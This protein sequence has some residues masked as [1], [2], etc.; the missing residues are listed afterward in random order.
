MP[1]QLLV[2]IFI[3]VLWMFLQNDWSISAF[4]LGYILGLLLIFLMRRFFNAP[5]Y[6]KRV[7]A[8]VSLLILFVRE[9][10]SSSI[11]ITK[12]IMSPKLTIKP[13]IFTME[14]SL[15]T[16]F[17][18]TL[19][20]LLL[21]LTPGS[22]VVELSEDGKTFYMHAMDIPDSS[23]MVL[24]SKDQFEKAIKGVTRDV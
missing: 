16:D 19:L 20:A 11:L 14:T 8:L 9:L 22:V 4:T 7:G 2:N 6:L 17:E 10:I 1:I 18:I 15:E 21:M 24:R 13:G 23:D 12:Q 5:F 3:A